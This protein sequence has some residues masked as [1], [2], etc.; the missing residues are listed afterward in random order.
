MTLLVHFNFGSLIQ[1][2]FLTTAMRLSML[3][4][5][6]PRISERKIPLPQSVEMILSSSVPVR[7]LSLQILRLSS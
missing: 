7:V 3:K 5:A 6:Y 2:N 1:K 4:F